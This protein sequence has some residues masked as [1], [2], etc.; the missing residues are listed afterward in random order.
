MHEGRDRQRQGDLRRRPRPRCWRSRPR[1][2]ARRSRRTRGI[3]KDAPNFRGLRLEDQGRGRRLLHLR[4][5]H[6]QRRGADLQGRRARRIPSAKLYGPDG[7]CESGFTNPK[8]KGIPASIG[9]K[10]K[11]TVATLDLNSYPGGKKFVADFKA[12]YGN[13]HPDPYAIYGYE[14]MK[15][16]ARHHQGGRQRRATT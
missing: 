4:G 5:R 12:K 13:A 15:L 3:Q 6:R 2:S 10:F 9:A 7:V 8:K 11:C 1:R 14:A 16:G